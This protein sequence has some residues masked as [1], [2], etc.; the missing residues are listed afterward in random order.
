MFARAR[1]RLLQTK[2][3]EEL[4]LLWVESRRSGPG[5]TAAFE[6]LWERHAI[7]SRQM[8]MRVLGRN[9]AF[10]DE[11]IQDA[12]LEVAR[13]GAYR[14]G[15]FRAFLRTV[16]TRKSLDF[17]ALSSVRA[18]RTAPEEGEIDAA[19]IVAAAPTADPQRTALAREGASRVLGIAER[20]PDAQ[21]VAWTLRYVEQMT[22]E[23]IAEAMAVPVGTAKTRVRLAN[24]FLAEGLAKLGI[25]AP[26]SPSRK[27]G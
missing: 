3:D 21:R 12:W 18:A 26:T 4:M 5:E 7:A 13:V 2:S 14:P 25:D 22:F 1:K 20:M 15:S 6:L 11:V 17:L 27:E 23:E 16:A 19:E 8:V 9:R 24:A 10:A